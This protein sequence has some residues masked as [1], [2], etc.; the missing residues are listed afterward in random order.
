MKKELV[1]SII[2]LIVV[3]VIAVL[4]VN[5]LYGGD[6]RCLVGRVIIRARK[7]N[8]EIDGDWENS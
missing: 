3:I 5:W 8:G 2:L 6:L 4:V 7:E 1:K